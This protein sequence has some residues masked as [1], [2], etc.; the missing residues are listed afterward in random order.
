MAIIAAGIVLPCEAQ[1]ES[2]ETRH[3]APSRHVLK[4]CEVKA[5]VIMVRATKGTRSSPPSA[6]AIFLLSSYHPSC[7]EPTTDGK[8]GSDESRRTFKL[9]CGANEQGAEDVS[10]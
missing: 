4:I 8:F 7:I 2:A 10:G 6:S 1:L 9:S 3:I 5:E